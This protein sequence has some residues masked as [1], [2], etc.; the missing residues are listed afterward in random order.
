MMIM[1]IVTF[2]VMLTIV[3]AMAIG[4]IVSN[5]P[6]K[7]SCGG[8]GALGVNS[9]CVICGGNPQR[10]DVSD[11]ATGAKCA[12]G[13]IRTVHPVLVKVSVLVVNQM[14]HHAEDLAF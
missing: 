3:A 12:E 9:A 7:G 6:I 14:V 4:V 2:L 13:M 8:M 1:M 10:C 5:K 11:C